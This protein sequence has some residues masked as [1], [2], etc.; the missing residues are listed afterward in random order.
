MPR[1]DRIADGETRNALADRDDFSRPLATGNKGQ[2]RLRLILA[3]DH[4]DIDELDPARRE[5]DLDFAGAGFGRLRQFAQHQIV[6]S[7]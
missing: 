7:P 5:R 1:H 4:Q 3:R 6:R 2:V